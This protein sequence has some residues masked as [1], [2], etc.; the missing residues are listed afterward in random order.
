MTAEEAE[1]LN[2]RLPGPLRYHPGEELGAARGAPAAR[3]ARGAAQQQR[4]AKAA[5]GRGGGYGGR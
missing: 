5:R 2:A 4:Q 3:A 1:A